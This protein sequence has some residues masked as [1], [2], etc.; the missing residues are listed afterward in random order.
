MHKN[1]CAIDY[2]H[3][4]LPSWFGDNRY[5]RPLA[6]RQYM[7]RSGGYIIILEQGLPGTWWIHVRCGDRQVK[8]AR[9]SDEEKDFLIELSPEEVLEAVGC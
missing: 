8:H 5:Q 1:W 4:H 2:R 3:D 7:S 6:G 9:A